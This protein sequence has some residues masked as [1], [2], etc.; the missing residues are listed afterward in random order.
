MVR[1]LHDSG[2]ISVTSQPFRLLVDCAPLSGGGGSQV[3]SA[4][5]E[6]LAQLPDVDWRAVATDPTVDALSQ[7]LKNDPR[8][9]RVKKLNLFDMLRIRK[10]LRREEKSFHPDI[11]FSV[12]GPT[13]FKP[14]A[15][16]LVG[17]ALP[18]MIYDTDPRM[19]APTLSE[20]LKEWI[21][22]RSFQSANSIV[23]ETETV[24]ERLVAQLGIATE[25]VS[26]IGNSVNPLFI[27][28]PAAA[29][30]TSSPVFRILVPSA[31][32]PHKNLEVI[33]SVAAELKRRESTFAFEFIF[34]LAAN[35]PQ[36]LALTQDAKKQ[37]VA[38]HL[39]SVGTL[40]LPELATQYQRSSVV[41][42]PTVRE[43]STA[44]YPESFHARR[45]LVTSDFDFSRELCGDAALYVPPF[46]PAAIADI[47]LGLAKDPALQATLVANGD[48]QLRKSYP[49]AQEK[50][51]QQ[52]Q[53][54]RTVTATQTRDHPK[55]PSSAV[56]WHDD[57]AADFSAAYARSSAFI[58]RYTV[59]QRLIASTVKKTDRVL[60]IGCGAGTFSFVAAKRAANVI[61]IDGSQ[62]MIE[63]ANSDKQLQKLDNVYFNVDLIE[64][65]SNYERGSFE[66]IMLS[67]VLEYIPDYTET[68]KTCCDILADGGHIILSMP[69]KSSIYRYIERLSF[70]LFRIPS[71]YRN[72][73]NVVTEEKL[74]DEMERAG[75]TIT[76]VTYYA[77]SPVFSKSLNFLFP[78]KRAKSLFALVAIKS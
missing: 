41:F 3:A 29:S 78:I 21:G 11:V 22:K 65:L 6:N 19:T 10:I 53:L 5:L 58:E 70:Y 15:P 33:P 46:D 13:Y 60:D 68:L 37:G 2:H 24:K 35:L 30:D 54:L 18:L 38:E 45:P 32:Y 36:W 42:L 75:F 34:T 57:N 77:D 28:C 1:S 39:R 23:V 69:N 40:T 61:A 49:T 71:Y 66:V 63:I 26:V 12:F 9:V 43:A 62:K 4:F 73:S 27:A 44:V 76:N 47:L 8:I 64:R 52:M 56:D 7:E 31:Y 20:K 51:A 48:V 17:F 67:S 74:S 72:V 14:K 55:L 25:R 50:F 16:H 59:W